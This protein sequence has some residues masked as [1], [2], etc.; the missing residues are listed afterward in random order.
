M[1]S[2]LRNILGKFLALFRP[3]AKKTR[4]RLKRRK[5]A[6]E[7][8]LAHLGGQ[9]DAEHAFIIMVV[10]RLFAATRAKGMPL[11]SEGNPTVELE[12]AAFHLYPHFGK[13]DERNYGVDEKI[14]AAIRVLQRIEMHLDAS[15][16]LDDDLNA[17]NVEVPSLV[18]ARHV[19]GSAFPDQTKREILG[20]QSPFDDWF[21]NELGIS[22][23]RALTI[24][25]AIE[26]GCSSSLQKARDDVP[27]MVGAT[28]AA[29][30]NG[31]VDHYSEDLAYAIFDRPAERMTV[32]RDDLKV[33]PKVDEKEWNAFIELVGI[34]LAKR[35][36]ITDPIELSRLP[37]YVTSGNRAIYYNQST[38]FDAIFDKFDQV[39]RADSSFGGKY[40]KNQT[41]WMEGE[42]TKSLELVFPSTSV[43][44]N[45]LYPDPNRPGGEAELDNLVVWGPFVLLIEAKGKQFRLSG[46]IG[47]SRSLKSDLK[48]NIQ[49]SLYYQASRAQRAIESV[50]EI[51]LR[52]RDSSRR[53]RLRRDQIDRF[54]PV[55]V[56]LHHLGPVTAQLSALQEMG[57]F[58]G[59]NYPWA[60]CL[61]DLRI[62][63]EHTANG[64]IFVHYVKRRFEMFAAE[65]TIVAG[66]EL[67]LFGHYLGTRLHPGIYWNKVGKNRKKYDAVA[68]ADGSSKINEWKQAQYGHLEQC[69]DIRLKVP[70][71]IAAILSELLK[72][73][74]NQSRGLALR[75]L[76]M[77]PNSLDHLAE[78]LSQIRTVA[79]SKDE[80]PSLYFKCQD[81]DLVITIVTGMLAPLE[82]VRKIAM[83][84]GLTEKYRHKAKAAIAFTVDG[85]QPNEAIDLASYFEFDWTRDPEMEKEIRQE[86]DVLPGTQTMEKDEKCFCG[87]G[88][89][90]GSCCMVR[91]AG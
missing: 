24:A 44:S 80:I 40:F 6:L 60:V 21:Q 69:P 22:P 4:E 41:A 81:D 52:E 42:V 46:R 73:E 50:D 25:E 30:I 58:S 20:I 83:A 86:I 15:R 29:L 75:I 35:S 62:I 70:A 90:F 54:F 74:D 26:T 48:S 3:S 5:A 7:N 37:V 88:E 91:I 82:D 39:A 33:S 72:R 64:D 79:R 87:S 84:R 53:I 34:T 89:P 56:S 67:D 8:L 66:D 71:E 17:P 14:D 12:L 68:I 65:T 59:G 36:R 27:A 32:G 57:L 43:F 18:N 1:F 49:D 55:A 61:A 45:V 85:R 9:T 63:S 19:R 76:D 31:P 13:S 16:Y 77:H 23:S 10:S 28:D 11:E 47:E 51:E 2:L 78:A 38:L